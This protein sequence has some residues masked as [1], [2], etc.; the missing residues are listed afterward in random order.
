[1]AGLPE[2]VM[3]ITIEF[4]P[5]IKGKTIDEHNLCSVHKAWVGCIKIMSALCSDVKINSFMLALSLFL[6]SL[7]LVG[8]SISAFVQKNEMKLYNR[9]V[10]KVQNRLEWIKYSSNYDLSW[11]D[12]EINDFQ[13]FFTEWSGCHFEQWAHLSSLWFGFA[14]SSGSDAHSKWEPVLCSD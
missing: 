2:H 1:M 7:A 12:E 14:H 13:R 5:W 10:K 11:K 6:F 8:V 4:S 3:I 9:L